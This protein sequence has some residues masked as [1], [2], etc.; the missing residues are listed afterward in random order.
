[1]VGNFSRVK[2]RSDP[3]LGINPLDLRKASI[4]FGDKPGSE[5]PDLRKDSPAEITNSDSKTPLGSIGIDSSDGTF[6]YPQT[7]EKMS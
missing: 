2:V 6:G 7:L 5:F 1:M 4:N 3:E